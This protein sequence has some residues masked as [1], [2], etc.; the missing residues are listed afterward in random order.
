MA[1]ERIVDALWLNP[2]EPLELTL[3]AIEQLPPG[4][5]VRLLIHREPQMLYSILDEWGF[6][7]QTTGQEDGTYEILIWQ[8]GTVSGEPINDQT[9]Q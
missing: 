4:D 2:P 6:A 9:S 8:E 1:Q 3:A 7:H 5:R